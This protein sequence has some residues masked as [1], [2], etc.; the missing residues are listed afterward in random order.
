[1]VDRSL[2]LFRVAPNGDAAMVEPPMPIGVGF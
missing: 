2:A 1:M